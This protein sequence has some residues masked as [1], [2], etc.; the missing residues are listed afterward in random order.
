MQKLG[1]IIHIG[2][3]AGGGRHLHEGLHRLLHPQLY[4][5]DGLSH[6][7]S[8]RRVQHWQCLKAIKDID[9]SL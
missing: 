7:F 1:F 4:P 2:G 5:A 8:D 9:G 6:T 3:F